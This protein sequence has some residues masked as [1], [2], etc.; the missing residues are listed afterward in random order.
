MQDST[1]RKRV[2]DRKL[3][4]AKLKALVRRKTSAWAKVYMAEP[5]GPDLVRSL[6]LGAEA[7]VR[8]HLGQMPEE[9]RE[10][11]RSGAISRAYQEGR[12][13]LASVDIWSADIF[14]DH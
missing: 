13:C 7:I 14:S 9:R 12:A 4:T 5:E 10:S 2:V 11:F 8:E 3:D 6:L 1:T